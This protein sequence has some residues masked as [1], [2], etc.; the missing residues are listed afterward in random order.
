MAMAMKIGAPMFAA[1][2]VNERANF[3]V[4]EVRVREDWRRKGGGFA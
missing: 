4:A 3:G 1:S 2:I